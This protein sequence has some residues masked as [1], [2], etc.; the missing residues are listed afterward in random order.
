VGFDI[1]RALHIGV[2]KKSLKRV[3]VNI[4]NRLLNY[5]DALVGKNTG[6]HIDRCPDCVK[7][8]N[9]TEQKNKSNKKHHKPEFKRM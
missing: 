7:G 1:K 8:C 2:I 5:V 4:I 6:G 9:K 3:R